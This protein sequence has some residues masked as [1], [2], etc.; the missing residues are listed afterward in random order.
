MKAHPC[1]C[2]R[3]HNR[4][5]KSFGHYIFE[6]KIEK[7]AAISFKT[8]LLSPLPTQ[9]NVENQVKLQVLVFDIVWGVLGRDQ[10][11]E[12]LFAS[13][14]CAKAPKVQ[15]CPETF[16]HDC[17]SCTKKSGSSCT[18]SRKVSHKWLATL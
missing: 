6:L 2:M 15:I 14:V 5:Q 9:H 17:I 8:A 16:V 18:S 4:S 12:L 11:G 7:N 10:A 1:A 13:G 3:N